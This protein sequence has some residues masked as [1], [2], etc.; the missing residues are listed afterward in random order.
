MQ[1]LADRL[2]NGARDD[3]SGTSLQTCAK[4]PVAG[5]GR[6]TA[7]LLQAARKSEKR[8]RI[9]RAKK[10]IVLHTFGTPTPDGANLIRQG[11]HECQAPKRPL[12]TADIGCF[13]DRRY[14]CCCSTAT[15]MAIVPGSRPW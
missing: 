9:N 8:T 6:E 7:R 12:T 3:D 14:C 1:S 10:R 5:I 11:C 15:L 4:R 2:F 13:V